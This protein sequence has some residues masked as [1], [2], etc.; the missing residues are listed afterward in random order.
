M[1]AIYSLLS[2]LSAGTNGIIAKRSMKDGD[3][4]V[5][6]A[7]RTVVVLLISVSAVWIGGVG[8]KI[9]E[10]DG[11]SLF[12]LLLSGVATAMAWLFYFHALETGSASGV[13][14]VDKFSIVLTML[15]GWL[16]LGES[17]NA[18]KLISMAMITVGI[19]LMIEYK[20]NRVDKQTA[21]SWIPWALLSVVSVTASTLF[22]KAGVESVDS[23]LA[24]T[25][26]T[27]VVL[28]VSGCAALWRISKGNVGKMEG[29]T[30]IF[31]GLSGAV[32]GIGWLFFF[33]ALAMGDAGIVHPI[34]K[35]SISVTVILSRIFYHTRLSL[36]SGL[37]L[38]T[39]SIGIFLLIL[40]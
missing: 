39:L 19:L 2:A 24:L 29:K 27:S 1:W 28:I 18:V 32:T 20:S 10:V 21:Y 25:I 34:D 12:F 13:A 11:R 4:A 3:A 30:L 9:F 8:K 26:R 14:A 15:G 38:M 16:I 5:V 17:M 36:R 40:I 37:G 33:K 6:T 31:V 7:L 35:L 23:R 22:S